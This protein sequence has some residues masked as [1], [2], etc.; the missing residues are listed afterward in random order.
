MIPDN[1]APRQWVGNDMLIIFKF[2]AG[3]E[4]IAFPLE[5]CRKSEF[6]PSHAAWEA[7]KT[8]PMQHGKANHDLCEASRAGSQFRQMIT[9]LL[10]LCG[11]WWIWGR[12]KSI[13]AVSL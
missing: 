12:E 8:L 6:P 1:V 11:I 7:K 5:S 9:V 4:K 13:L 3:D 10:L 2:L